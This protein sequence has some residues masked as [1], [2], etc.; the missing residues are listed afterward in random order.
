MVGS[1]ISGAGPAD[2]WSLGLLALLRHCGSNGRD[3]S[4]EPSAGQLAPVGRWTSAPWRRWSTCSVVSTRDGRR[5]RAGLAGG[6][7]AHQ[8]RTDGEEDD[9]HALT[10]SASAWCSRMRQEGPLMLK[11][12]ARCMSR[13]KIAE[14]TTASPNTSP[15]AGKPLLV[16]AS[17]GWPFS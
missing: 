3:G 15:Q 12:T 10:A 9:D 8:H 1:S 11:T 14:A 7:V 13:S 2:G 17:V 6:L 4:L 16:V 5:A